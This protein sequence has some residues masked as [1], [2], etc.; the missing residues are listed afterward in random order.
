VLNCSIDNARD[1][2]S[3]AD[4]AEMF[5]GLPVEHVLAILRFAELHAADPA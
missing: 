1:G 3:P 5:E 2:F 4:M